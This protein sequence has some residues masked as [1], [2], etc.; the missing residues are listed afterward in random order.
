MKSFLYISTYPQTKKY[1]VYR[2]VII[3]CLFPLCL[4]SIGSPIK[5]TK[6][7]CMVFECT[8]FLKVVCLFVFFLTC[9]LSE[10]SGLP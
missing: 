1:M 4:K 10:S 9:N 3:T 5:Q 2:K 6:K 8:V 7:G